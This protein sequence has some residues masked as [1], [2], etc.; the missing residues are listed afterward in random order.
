MQYF[1]DY[2]DINI[3]EMFIFLSMIFKIILQIIGNFVLV[4]FRLL[5]LFISWIF[6]SMKPF[7]K[8][9]FNREI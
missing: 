7:L 1:K 9:G 4:Q 6:F 5:M 3:K 8:K 2:I